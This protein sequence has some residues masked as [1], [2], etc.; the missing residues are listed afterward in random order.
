MQSILQKVSIKDLF[1][2]GAHLGHKKQFWN[3]NMLPYIYGTSNTDTHII[4]LQKTVPLLRRALKKISEVISNSGR[5]LFVGTKMQASSVI[6]EEALRCGQ[7][8]VNLRWPSGMLTNWNTISKSIKKLAYYEKLLEKDSESL[9]KKEILTINRNI[10]KIEKYLGGVR[11]MGGLPSLVFVIDPYKEHIAVKE[12]NKL[13]IP[14]V[15]VVDTNCNPQNIA[16]PIPGNDDSTRAIQYYCSLISDAA[17]A[18][19]EYEL[20]RKSKIKENNPDKEQDGDDKKPYVRRD[21]NS[22]PRV[23]RPRFVRDIKPQS[24]RRFDEKAEFLKEG[25]TKKDE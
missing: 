16:Y 7:C 3:P 12:A 10:E 13:G 22:R 8:Y 23:A 6:K 11:K 1:E 5:I 19:I 24:N 4:N 2:A 21:D 20:Q 9:N 15:A 25:E 14:I 17:L 18:G